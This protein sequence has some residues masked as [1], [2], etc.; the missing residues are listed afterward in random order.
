MVRVIALCLLVAGCAPM[1]ERECR[2]DDWYAQGA[3][4]GLM[5]GPP[6]IDLYASQCT[7]YR[8]Q[9]SERD[10]MAG[11]AAGASEYNTRVGGSKM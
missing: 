7:R 11:W 8:L 10:Y 6:K 5:G 1:S 2:V 3:R 4:D 9:P